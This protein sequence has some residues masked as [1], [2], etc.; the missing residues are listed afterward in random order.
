MSRRP[1][2]H[3]SSGADAPLAITLL[4]LLAVSAPAQ[5]AVFYPAVYWPDGATP[6]EALPVPLETGET[7]DDLELVLQSSGG[8]LSGAVREIG[9]EAVAGILVVAEAGRFRSHAVTAGDGSYRIDGLAPGVHQVRAWTFDLRSSRPDLLPLYA[10]AAV[11]EGDAGAYVVEAGETTTGVDITL[12]PGAVI[13]GRV[14]VSDSGD[15]LARYRVEGTQVETG[16]TF[17]TKTDESGT[18]RLEG[19]APGTYRVAVRTGET[20]FLDEYYDG[21]RDPEDAL[22]L[23]L[24]NEEVTIQA[25]IALDRQARIFG[26]VREEDGPGG[27]ADVAVIAML[28]DSDFE[29]RGRTDSQGFYRIDKLR[30]GA[31]LVYVPAI[32]RYYPDATSEDEARLVRLDEGE[33]DF[34]VNIEGDRLPD[35]P[36]LP[37]LLGVITGDIN[38]QGPDIPGGWT[39]RAESAP[40]ARELFVETEGSY[41]LNCLIPGSY[42]VSVRGDSSYARQ[43]FDET[44]DPSGAESVFVAASDTADA[45]DFTPPPGAELGGRVLA[46]PGMT[47]VSGAPVRV[48]HQESGAVIETI[49]DAS[50]RFG[51]NQLPSG[52]GL[53]AGAYTVGVDS[54]ST[55]EIAPTPVRIL[56]AWAEVQIRRGR[57]VVV[58]RVRLPLEGG[59]YRADLYRLP[60]GDVPVRVDRITPQVGSAEVIELEDG[61]P[62]CGRQ[63]Y[64]VT[65]VAAGDTLRSETLAVDVGEAAPPLVAWAAAPNPSRRGWELQVETSQAMQLSLQVV[66]VDGRLVW[67]ENRQVSEG[68]H[69]FSWDG[70]RRDGRPAAPGLYLYVLR[71]GEPVTLAGGGSAVEPGRVLASGRVVRLR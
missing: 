37:E 6:D 71:E 2:L 19:L 51:V 62:P 60:P 20:D 25:D 58:A 68:R 50:G 55:G 59:P 32:A 52:T 46:E 36:G 43:Y 31:Y 12:R 16:E 49:T 34:D 10:P 17:W 39:V 14:E 24:P 18:Y 23:T 35:C 67:T 11:E 1:R 7:R 8:A 54:F 65:A 42:L 66:S 21:A 13:T 47:P 3:L 9:G 40:Y 38:P 61:D 15:A 4:L 33:N 5:D 27:I 30:A 44:N 53:P 56:E 48:V 70:R 57:W 45:V 29:R 22:W 26:V 28:E 41:T 63:E 64:R 69:E